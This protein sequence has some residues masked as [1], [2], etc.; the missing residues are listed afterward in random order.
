MAQESTHG[1]GSLSRTASA[2]Y[3]RPAWRIGSAASKSTPMSSAG[4]DG[5]AR[6][7][8]VRRGQAVFESEKAGCRKCHVVRDD[9]RHADSNFGPGPPKVHVKLLHN[10]APAAARVSIVGSDGKP[11]GPIGAAIR[12]TKRDESYFYAV[13][14][15]DVELPPG[16]ARLTVNGGV[17]TIPQ[18]TTVDAGSTTELVVHMKQ[19][20]DMA[21]RG[22][23]SGDSHV[24]LH[25]GGPIE[26][27]V[28]DALAASRAE[29]VNYVNLCVSNN[30]GDDIRDADLITGKPAGVS[31]DRH[32][33]VFGEEMRSTIYGHMQFFGINKLVEPQCEDGR[34]VH[35]EKLARRTQGRSQF[36]HERPHAGPSSQR[37]GPGRD[38]RT[39]NRRE[40]P[41]RRDGGKP[42]PD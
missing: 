7:E 11:Y 1:A 8:A 25:T 23:Y 17:E 3:F 28:A 36:R 13:D 19:W 6:A 10:C 9:E 41:R 5:R 2:S 33:L 34:S 22:W 42:C 20:V 35:D 30:V 37:Q 29:G 38:D 31:T 4:I 26:V 15:F 16:H 12:K 21:A 18:T 24:H 40:R 27:T 39:R 14:S 32:L